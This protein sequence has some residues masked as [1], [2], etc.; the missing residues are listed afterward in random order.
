MV[1][2]DVLF[3][4]NILL[5]RT[6]KYA[7][8]LV[9]RLGGDYSVRD[10]KEHSMSIPA[11]QGS[12]SRLWL[13]VILAMAGSSFSA[14]QGLRSSDV[15]IA[16]PIDTD[17]AG[18]NGVVAIQSV[19]RVLCRKEDT[20]GTGF[21][22]KSG[23]IITANHVVEKCSQV[24]IVLNTGKE[25]D[26]SVGS[27]DVDL[28]LALVVPSSPLGAPSLPISSRTFTNLSIG[29]QVSTWGFPGGYSGLAPLVSAGYLAGLDVAR[30]PNG[31]IIKTTN[32][33]VV[34]QWV[35]NAAFNRGN[36]GGPLLQ[37]ETGEVIGVVASKL[38]PISPFAMMALEA[39]QKQ[40]SGFSYEATRPDGSKF[41]FSEGQ[42][43][44]TVLEELR[45]Q[46]Q[47]V[48]GKAVL[49]D[50]VRNFLRSQRLEP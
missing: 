3:H 30:R 46:V 43:V 6:R 16:G 37:I 12:A 11:H 1:L 13:F 48:I 31:E 26:A 39:L 20:G 49:S 22:H 4:H 23:K 8:G 15:P 36:S 42:V 19:V 7:A 29:A 18:K 27:K 50:D 33:K 9:N 47:L 45:N 41:K 32:D 38:A 24:S 2:A 28:D 34:Q 25:L 40:S 5:D 10:L 35:V 17:S 44:A 21:L 14:A